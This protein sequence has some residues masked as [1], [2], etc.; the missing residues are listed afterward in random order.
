[1]AL[2]FD[3]TLKDMGRDCPEGF[4]AEFDRPPPASITLLNVDLSAVTR[5]ADL[6]VGLGDPMQEIVHIE[7]QS[8][9]AA[10]KHAEVLVY[11]ALVYSQHHVPVH[12]IVLLLRPEAAHENMTGRVCYAPRPEYGNMDFGYRVVRLWEIDAERLIGGE[13]G[14][15]PL[16][17]LGRFADGVEVET[18]V[19]AMARRIVERITKEASPDRAGKLLAR[20]LLLAGLRVQRNVAFEIFEGVQMMEESDTYLAILDQ[21]EERGLRE[22]ILINGEDRLGSPDESVKKALKDITDLVRLKRLVRQALKAASW[23]EILGTP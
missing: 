13:L 9:A 17:V 1:M 12:S 21:G 22:A 18:G 11:N 14:I 4:L 15:I 16:A 2:T 23:Q 6:I 10:W 5:S 19:A 7:F 8:S 20:A 3:A